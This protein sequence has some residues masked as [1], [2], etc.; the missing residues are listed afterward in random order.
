MHRTLVSYLHQLALLLRRER[1]R[2]LN[3]SIDSIEH[4][5]VPDHAVEAVFGVNP[6]VSQADN[7]GLERPLFRSRIECDGHGHAGAECGHEQIV[8]TGPTVRATGGNRLIRGEMMTA[9]SDLLDKP[10][11]PTSNDNDTLCLG[12]RKPPLGYPL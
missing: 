12:H 7:D 8:R 4:G 2:E 1:A 3:L 5:I 6:R 11:R 9:G 10:L